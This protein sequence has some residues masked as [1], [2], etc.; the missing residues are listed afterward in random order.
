MS[1]RPSKWDRSHVRSVTASSRNVEKG[2]FACTGTHCDASRVC[3]ALRPRRRKIPTDSAHRHIR[4]TSRHTICCRSKRAI[5]TVNICNANCDADHS[6]TTP[7]QQR[8]RAPRNVAQCRGDKEHGP[9]PTA[10]KFRRLRP[11]V[12]CCIRKRSPFSTC[13]PMPRSAR[14]KS[15]HVTVSGAL[16]QPVACVAG[17]ELPPSR[18]PRQSADRAPR[19]NAI[20][21]GTACR[22]RT[23]RAVC[24][25]SPR[26]R[27]PDSELKP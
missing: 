13:G 12:A 20:L 1:L 15:C 9:Q 24:S 17:C 11:T 4:T 21:G 14:C 22:W 3:G 10:E 5:R 6:P 7:N 16:R 2:L 23:N 27:H 19:P 18:I 26:S 8:S 25:R